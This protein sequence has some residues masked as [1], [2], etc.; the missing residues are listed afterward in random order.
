MTM[1]QINHGRGDY[2]CSCIKAMFQP[3]TRNV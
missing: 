2:W 3:K 1:K